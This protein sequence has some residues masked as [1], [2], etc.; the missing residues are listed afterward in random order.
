VFAYQFVLAQVFFCSV[1]IV[2]WRF[3]F[4]ILSLQKVSFLFSL[5][6]FE[7]FGFVFLST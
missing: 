2:P 6:G 7:F 1:V 3:Q 4:L 5:V